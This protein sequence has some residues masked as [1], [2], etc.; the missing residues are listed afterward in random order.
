MDI[1]GSEYPWIKSVSEEMLRNIKQIVIEF[2]GI[3]DNTHG[4]RFQ[5]KIKCFEK[6]NKT[7]YIVHIHANNYADVVFNSIP[8]V[9]ELTYINKRYFKRKPELNKHHLPI[10]NLDYPNNIYSEDIDLS[11]FILG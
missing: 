2:H 3:C 11:Y 1:E 10:N 8:I 6:L 7:H 4:F 9:I 5:D